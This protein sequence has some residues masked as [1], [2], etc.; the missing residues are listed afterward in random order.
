M[1]GDLIASGPP[2]GVG[3][4]MTPPEFLRA[5]DQVHCEIEGIGS[6]ESRVADC[7]ASTG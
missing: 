6:L 7:G 4:S 3:A 2:V 1:P 5:G